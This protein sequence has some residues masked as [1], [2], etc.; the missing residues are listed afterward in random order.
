MYILLIIIG[1]ALIATNIRAIMREENNFSKAM[2]DAESNI[3]EVDMRIVEIRSEFAKTITEL[4]R[5]INDLKKVNHTEFI[6]KGL[7]EKIDDS[8]ISISNDEY[9]NTL[10]DKIDSLDD[11]IFLQVENMG[12]V[13]DDLKE[14]EKDSNPKKDIKSNSLKVEEVKELLGE[15]LSEESIAQ[16]LNI[17]KGEVLLIKELYLK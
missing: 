5:E 11:N 9:I 4:Q 2:I 10:V 6:E 1:V 13:M 15:G 7:L 16:R 3:D 12:E 14:E 8:D 17:G